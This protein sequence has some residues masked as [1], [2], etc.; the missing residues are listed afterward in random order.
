MR[1]LPGWGAAGTGLLLGLLALPMRA[2]AQPSTQPP[3]SQPP[4]PSA[5]SDIRPA[6]PPPLASATPPLPAP[7]TPP[8]LRPLAQGAPLEATSTVASPASAAAAAPSDGASPPP[9]PDAPPPGYLRD[10]GGRLMQV[11]FD[12]NRRFWL[13]GGWA[14]VFSQHGGRNLQRGLLEIGARSDVVSPDGRWRGRFRLLE[15]EAMLAPIEA[16]GVALRYDESRES[17]TPFVRIS[18][19]WPQPVRHDV[20]LN[21]GFWGEALGAEL[22]PRGSEDE[23]SVRFVGMGGTWDVWHDRELEDYLRVRVG[24]AVDDRLASFADDDPGGVALTPLARIEADVI[25]DHAGHHRVSGDVG[26]EVPVFVEQDVARRVRRRLS[27]S[28]GYELVFL[29]INDQPLSLRLTGT[30]GYRDDLARTAL[31]GWDVGGLAS[32]RINLWVPPSYYAEAHAERAARDRRA[33]APAATRTTLASAAPGG[34][35]APPAKRR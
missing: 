16:R 9:P 20:Y 1:A 26:V 5:P 29:A 25:V 18:T 3:V 27:A 11:E 31:H 22:R 33:A 14:P 24:G 23:G 6:A 10:A 17:E 15:G 8:Q 21:V 4:S 30:G 13:G 2:Q 19:F 7:S 35:A 32:M 34:P 12:M 28:L